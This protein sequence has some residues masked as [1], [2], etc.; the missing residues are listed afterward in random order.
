MKYLIHLF[1]K[2]RHYFKKPSR[3]EPLK[4]IRKKPRVIMQQ[5]VEEDTALELAR[6]WDT[7][8]VKCPRH[9]RSP[10]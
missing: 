3:V 1:Y 7:E 5:Q 4:P 10:E 8:D 2:L 9:R 6:Q